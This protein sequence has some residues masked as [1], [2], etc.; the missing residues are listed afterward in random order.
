MPG[1]RCRKEQRE[2]GEPL[3][4]AVEVMKSYEEEDDMQAHM[5]S[6]ELSDGFAFV[7]CFFLFF[8][9]FQQMLLADDLS[10]RCLQLRV[11]WICRNSQFAFRKHS[12]CHMNNMKLENLSDMEVRFIYSL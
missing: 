7:S 10:L 1:W 3:G 12:N 4:S 11:F 8:E 5:N 9:N 6:T 2:E